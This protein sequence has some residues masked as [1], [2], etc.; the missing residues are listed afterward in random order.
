MEEHVHADQRQP[1]PPKTKSQ[2][3]RQHIL[4]NGKERSPGRTDD[5]PQRVKLKIKNQISL[6]LK[7]PRQGLVLR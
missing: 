1:H 4:L 6:L 3:T 2:I 7:R 5:A